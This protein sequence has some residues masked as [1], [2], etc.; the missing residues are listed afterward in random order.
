MRT[1]FGSYIASISLTS[2]VILL[3][4]MTQALDALSFI[5]AYNRYGLS[6]NE[7]L[8]IPE[9]L[10]TNGGLATVLLVKVAGIIGMTLLLLY[11]A[12][13]EKLWALAGAYGVIFAGVLGAFINL[14][15]ASL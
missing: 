11:L 14:W 2:K 7:L 4:V 9:V 5:M 10:Y 15:A 12:R 8:P 3:A 6:G 1:I 13:H